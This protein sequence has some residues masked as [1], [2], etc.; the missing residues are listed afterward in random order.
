MASAEHAA[1]ASSAPSRGKPWLKRGLYLLVGLVLLVPVL[2][3]LGPVVPVPDYP[4]AVSIE[5]SLP[6]PQG[7]QA[8]PASDPQYL[9]QLEQRIDTAEKTHALRPDNQARII[10][11]NPETR[12]QT[13]LAL[14]YFHG[15]SASPKELSPT[16]ETVAHKLGAN[17]Y[18][19]R[20]TGHGEDGASLGNT[21]A[22]RWLADIELGWQIGKALGQQVAFVGC[23]T[24]ATLATIAA[25]HH[26]DAV[27]LV[28]LSPNF[29][30]KD[31]NSWHLIKPWGRE[32]AH[33]LI[34]NERSWTPTNEMH[35]QYWTYRY[36][37]DVLPHVMRTVEMARNQPLESFQVPALCLYT[38]TDK[39]L[40]LQAITSQCGRFKDARSRI[41]IVESAEDH[42]MA[43][44]VLGANST[45]E[46][47]KRISRFLRESL[48]PSALAAAVPDPTE[49]SGSASGTEDSSAGTGSPAGTEAEPSK[50]A[51]NPASATGSSAPAGEASAG[52]APAAPA[53][54]A[55]T[56][57][58][59]ATAH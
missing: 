27:A 6:L 55:A 54:E 18:L 41:Q 9:A 3:L 28:L 8:V 52:S 38:P 23:S 40:D 29:G 43:G 13:P 21:H 2:Y 17:L 26:P 46:V 44:D 47:V 45:A 42:V 56:G 37:V 58:A 34:G 4:A 59:S 22:D 11:A 24:G 39:S 48:P 36:G 16:L 10:W 51:S 1:N 30:P 15:F 53:G 35:A 57:G 20:L 19:A 32:L 14:V 49:P 31:P 33:L 12:V 25:G 5:E 50:A 7:Q